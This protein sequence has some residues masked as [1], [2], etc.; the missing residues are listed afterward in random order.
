LDDQGDVVGAVFS[1][2]DVTD[3]KFSEERQGNFFAL[4]TD[5]MGI[6][7]TEG[8]FVT[9]NNAW[10]KSLGWSAEELLNKP[11]LSLVH[12]DD[13][14]ATI[15]MAGRLKNGEKVYT[16]ENRYLCKDG[17]YKWISWNSSPDKERKLIFFVARDVTKQIAKQM[18]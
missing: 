8:Y 16:F 10:E 13:R 7:S 14:E 3:R 4:S 17:S 9:I 2:R 18:N 15:K 5:V 6:A 12:P 1:S 11:Y